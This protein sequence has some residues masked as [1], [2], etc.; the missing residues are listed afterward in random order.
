MTVG[1]KI[2][3]FASYRVCFRTEKDTKTKTK[4]TRTYMNNLTI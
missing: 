2:K 3:M 1:T 4:N